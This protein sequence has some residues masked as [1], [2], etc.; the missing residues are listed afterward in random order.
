VG[1]MRSIIILA[2]GKNRR[3]KCNKALMNLGGKPLLNH[4]LDR[5]LELKYETIVLIGRNDE[6]N[7]YSEIIS[8]KIILLKDEENNMGPLSGI[9]TG[10]QHTNAKYSLVL[11]CDSPFVKNEVLEYLFNASE[12]FD[13]SIPFWPNGYIEPLHAV[14][15]VKKTYEA[16]KNALK[17]KDLSLRSVIKRLNKVNYIKIE[18]IKEID[19][20]LITFFNI[21]SKDDLQRAKRLLK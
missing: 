2:G 12:G 5:V 17:N 4:I 6:F 7:N 18:K 9:L 13:A 8:P 1:L 14:Y 10:M 19:P 11:P 21:N 3:I 15:K 16:T 20:D